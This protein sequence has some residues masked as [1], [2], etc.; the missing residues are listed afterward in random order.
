[1]PEGRRAAKLRYFSAGQRVAC[2]DDK[3]YPEL[4]VA[5]IDI[6]VEAFD[7]FPVFFMRQSP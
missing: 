3:D 1:M 4:C 7:V 2:K 5:G 6:H